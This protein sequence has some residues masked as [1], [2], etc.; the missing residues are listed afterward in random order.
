MAL[1]RSPKFKSSNPK[2]SQ[3]SFLVPGPLFEKTQ[4]SSTMQSSRP[5]FKHLSQLVLKQKIFFILPIYF[6]ASNPGASSIRPFWALGP[7]FE[8]TW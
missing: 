3:Q 8:Q 1:D 2:P 6:Y 4:K 5:I 7:W